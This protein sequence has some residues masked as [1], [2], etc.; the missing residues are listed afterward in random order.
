MSSLSLS[1]FS[2]S[3]RPSMSPITLPPIN[4]GALLLHAG[5]AATMAYGYMGLQTL[6]I[7]AFIASQKGGHFQFLTILGLAV[8]F[9]TMLLSMLADLAPVLTLVKR[10]KRAVFMIAMPLAVVIST[11]YWTLLFVCPQLILREDESLD[12]E[13][14]SSV[15]APTFTR[16]PLQM[17]I[18]LHAVPAIS[19]LLD[20]FLLERKYSTKHAVYGG[21]IVAASSGIWYSWWVEECGKYNG[22]FPYPFLTFSPFHIR[23]AIYSVA[24]TFAYVCFLVLNFIRR[25]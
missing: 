4:T 25:A 14:S 16:I 20:F 6:P 8:A 15:E 18:A 5:A 21:F 7:H 13:P 2:P 1:S 11:I 23:I 12:T 10:T 19:L 9:V 17:D 22:I 3:L 24:T